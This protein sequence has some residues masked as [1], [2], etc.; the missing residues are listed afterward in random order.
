MH[1]HKYTYQHKAYSYHIWCKAN[2]MR[3]IYTCVNIHTNIS[4]YISHM[5]KGQ[6]DVQNLGILSHLPDSREGQP[7]HIGAQTAYVLCQGLGQHVYAPLHQVTGCCPAAQHSTLAV[8][9]CLSCS[10]RLLKWNFLACSK[11]M[12]TTPSVTFCLGC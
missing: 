11:P 12:R 5:E 7:L 2:L 10:Q 1:T 9:F 8:A 4:I 3:T 6:P